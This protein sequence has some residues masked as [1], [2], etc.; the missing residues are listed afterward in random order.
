MAIAQT[1]KKKRKII[2]L[3]G[4]LGHPQEPWGGSTGGGPATLKFLKI[5]FTFLFFYFY[6]FKILINFFI[7]LLG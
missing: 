6:F 4:W 5:F 3:W 7:F 2:G 1:K